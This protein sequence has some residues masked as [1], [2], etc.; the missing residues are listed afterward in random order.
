MALFL[1][2]L[3]ILAVGG[4]FYGKY[5]EKVFGPDDRETPPFAWRTASTTLACPKAKTH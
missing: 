2:G 4:F 1:I 3:V 5:V